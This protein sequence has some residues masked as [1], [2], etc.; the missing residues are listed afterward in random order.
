MPIGALARAVW[1]GWCGA[2]PDDGDSVFALDAPLALNHAH[3][4]L[5]GAKNGWG[6]VTGPFAAAA[7]SANRLQWQHIGGL[8]YR[9][10]A[11]EDLSLHVDSPKAVV[12]AVR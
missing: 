2:H 4:K 10:D 6:S 8:T 12:E 1:E 5:A 11:G 9:I 7:A 3:R